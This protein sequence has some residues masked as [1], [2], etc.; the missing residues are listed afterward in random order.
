MLCGGKEKRTVGSAHVEAS[1][2]HLGE[3]RVRA[4]SDEAVELRISENDNA[5]SY[6]DQKSEIDVVALGSLS[7]LV[8][9]LAASSNQVNTLRRV[10]NRTGRLES[11]F[12][13]QKNAHHGNSCGPE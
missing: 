5:T 1:Q 3:L 2:H 6:L 7:C 8:S 10:R 12:T 11:E 4:T 9:A 13:L